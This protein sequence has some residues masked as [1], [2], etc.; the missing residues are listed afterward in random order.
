MLP[1]IGVGAAATRS[2]GW[3]SGAMFARPLQPFGMPPPA[4]AIDA[5]DALTVELVEPP[6]VEVSPVVVL[7]LLVAEHAAST[8]PTEA[9]ERL[10]RIMA[11]D[12]RGIRR[13]RQPSTGKR[14]LLPRN[15]AI[16]A[17]PFRSASCGIHRPAF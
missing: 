11:S 12:L 9:K 3:I 1:P 5:L 6:P 2:V 14:P 15:V 16:L 17:P 4:L 8:A 13:G 10:R 7:L